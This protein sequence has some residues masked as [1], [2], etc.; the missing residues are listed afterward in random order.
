MQSWG[1]GDVL[2]GQT[3]TTNLM[4]VVKRDTTEVVMV[5]EEVVKCSLLS[6]FD[7]RMQS[8]GQGDVLKGH[9]V[10]TFVMDVVKND[11]TEVVMV[12]VTG[13]FV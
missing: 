5:V 11:T 3:V 7:I 12:V 10:T 6:Q 9:T 4:D 2:K 1:Q 8:Q 13:N